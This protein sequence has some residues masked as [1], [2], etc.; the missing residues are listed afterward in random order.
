MSKAKWLTATFVVLPSHFR[1]RAFAP[2][3]DS[4]P[5]LPVLRRNLNERRAL[6]ASL[7]L[8]ETDRRAYR[9]WPNVRYLRK[10]TRPRSKSEI[11]QSC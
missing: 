6:M 5:R 8:A 3:Q 11:D 10:W 1:V 7:H 2:N 4:F 9:F